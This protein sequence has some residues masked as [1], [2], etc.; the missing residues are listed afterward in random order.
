MFFFIVI[1][2]HISHY[3]PK[4]DEPAVHEPETVLTKALYT[5]CPALSL[6]TGSC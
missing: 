1:F 5:Y 2:P 3:V 6:E 4:T